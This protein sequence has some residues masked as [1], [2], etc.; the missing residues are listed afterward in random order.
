MRRPIPAS[1]L[2]SSFALV[3]LAAGA[4]AFAQT[5]GA[6]TPAQDSGPRRGTVIRE[7]LNPY[8]FQPKND[9]V[10]VDA[11]TV[12]FRKL[13]EDLGPDAQRW[14]QHV[15]TL[16]N[17]WFEGRAPGSAGHDRAAEYLAW[18]FE[19]TRLAPAFGGGSEGTPATWFQPFELTGRARSVTGANVAF[20]GVSLERGKDFAV[21]GVSGAGA[22]TA[23]V[24]FAGYAIAEGKDGYTSFDGDDDLAGRI[25]VFMRYEP[26]DAEGRSRWGENRFSS[27]SNIQAKLKTLAERGAAAIVLVNPPGVRDGR[28]GL[29]DERS[30]RWGD[31][32]KVP[33]VQMSSASFDAFLAKADAEGRT[34]AALRGAADEGALKDFAFSDDVRMTVAV[35]VSDGTVPAK[36]VG[37][38]LA[39]KGA[40]K[41]EW[42]IV[43]GHFDHVGFGFFGADPANRGQL[44]PG[45]DDNASGTAALLVLAERMKASYDAAPADA[46]LRSVMFLGFSAEESGLEGSRY[47]TKH[48][49]I[50]AE[51]V[52]AMLNLDMVGRL[53]SDTL[54]VG[55]VGSASNF[56][57]VLD[58]IF[59]ASGL[60]IHADPSGRGPS[61]HA[62]FFNSGIPVLFFFTGTHDIYHRPG[63]HGWTVNPAGA[64]KVLGL[65]RSIADAL[66]SG[67]K[68]VFQG[69]DANVATPDRGYGPVRLGIMPAM[70][71]SDVVGVKVESVSAETSAAEAGI[72]PGDVLVSWNGEDLTSTGDMMS[73]LRS[74]KPGDVVKI[75]VVRDGK[76]IPLD[77]KLKAGR[78]RGE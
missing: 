36:N 21:L 27:H 31:D 6:A 68:L 30:S 15:Q 75:V 12:D 53:R 61:D 48:S 77:V 23:P 63:D 14:Y 16:S 70:G 3:V 44:H 55:G 28:D 66:V 57:E 59:A 10:A 18:W 71:E 58:P 25:V 11:T 32:L 1:S 13:F 37:A 73:R 72:K 33:F 67:P 8:R 76:E 2:V 20:D 54:A 38:V 74:H 43:G 17:P 56:G 65:V 40:L 69:A 34:L 29:E 50:A 7:P 42:L 52:T 45:A 62:S 64:V 9:A 51:K 47:F 4:P 78:P 46:N 22:V 60:E 41:D 24:A 35:E 49:P 19:H 39:G 5:D 26:I